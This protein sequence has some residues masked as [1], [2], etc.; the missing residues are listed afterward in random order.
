M[1][2]QD[3]N[4]IVIHEGFDGRGFTSENSLAKMRMSKPDT[5]NPV[6]THLMGRENKKFPLTFM[7]EGQE[8]GTK[9]IPLNDI[10]YKFPV[11]GRL[12]NSDTIV[13]VEGVSSGDDGDIGK[14]GEDLYVV[15]KT[16][17]MKKNHTIISRSGVQCRIQR[18]GEK[19][20]DGYRYKIILIYKSDSENIPYADLTKGSKWSMS[21]GAAVSQSDSSGNESNVQSPGELKNQI[22]ILRKSF[23]VAGNVKNKVVEFQFNV[24][25]KKTSRWMPFQEYQHDLQ[26]K[27]A[28]EEHVW[29][30]K[31]NRDKNGNITTIDDETGLPIPFG[32]GVDDQIPNRD[33]YGFLTSRKLSQ[34]ISDVMY[35]ATD[36]GVMDIVLYTGLGGMDEFDQA[37]KRDISGGSSVW[38]ALTSGN[39]ADKFIKGSGGGNNL[40]FGAYFTQYRHI[41]GHVVTV[42]HLPLLDFGG[43]AESSD[44][45]PITG[46]PLTSYEMYFLD[47]SN[48]DGEKNIKM[49][50]EKGRSMLRGVEQGMSLI[51]GDSYGDYKGN[52]KDLILATD[53]DRS[54][55][56]MLK[57][58]GVS[59][60]RNTH[61][62]KLSCV[63]S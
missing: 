22:S 40:S 46:K 35:G 17:W 52:A 18:K 14:G 37:I 53:V 50:H 31:Y 54:S 49:V 32:A 60:S 5:I 58:L 28:C 55:V 26:F 36:T 63:L 44:L 61:C 21:G 25:G 47:H 4:R 1:V 6:I 62:F 27:Q 34:T 7:T 11:M 12:K 57:T 23:S 20:S 51:K 2:R 42:K 30:S 45:H 15:F 38:T 48:Y 56:H 16:N 9:S 33:T 59:I 19:V 41:D 10:Q 13:R 43:R 24:G 29:E 8:G 3:D 39:A